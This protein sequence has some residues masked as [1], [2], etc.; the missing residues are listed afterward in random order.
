MPNC[1]GNPQI[2]AIS[3]KCSDL[4]SIRVEIDSPEALYKHHEGYVPY[5]LGIGQGDYIRF[6][7]CLSCGQIQEFSTPGLSDFLEGE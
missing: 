4:F 1:C 5:G 3:G 2:A 7:Y 6:K